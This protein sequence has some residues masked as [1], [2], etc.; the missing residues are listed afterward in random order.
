[1]DDVSD[2][3]EQARQIA[4]QL[5]GQAATARSAVDAARAVNYTASVARGEP[6]EVTA[7]ADGTGCLTSVYVGPAAMHGGPNRLSATLVRVLNE[8]LRGVALRATEALMQAAGPAMRDALASAGRPD[9][10]P[11][12]ADLA[13]RLAD[14]QGT[15]R[16][17]GTEVTV[18]A[19]GSGTI[20]AV[21][22]SAMATRGDDNIRLGKQVTAAANAALAAA[23]RPQQE[24]A[25]TLGRDDAD[26]AERLRASTSRFRGQMDGLL[27]ELDQA[28]HRIRGLE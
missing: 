26:A 19:A 20:T 21:R 27:A 4:A 15:G 11:A 24:L 18:A 8:A 22:L 2:L 28:E 1:M 9:A 17:P 25:A 6:A 23:R 12:D 3:A 5:R 7:T 10:T 14:E 16:S 13:K